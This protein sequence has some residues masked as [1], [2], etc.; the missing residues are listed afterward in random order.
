[1]RPRHAAKKVDEAEGPETAAWN[2][3][4]MGPTPAKLIGLVY[5]T[6]AS[7]AVDVAIKERRAEERDRF[8]LTAHRAF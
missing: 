1:L 2:V 4:K 8:R 6:T 3:Y 7:D 5:A